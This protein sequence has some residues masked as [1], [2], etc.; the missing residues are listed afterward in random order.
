MEK[1]KSNKSRWPS[2]NAQEAGIR[3]FAEP[4]KK[5]TAKEKI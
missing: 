5:K 3:L 4:L 1:V 2:E